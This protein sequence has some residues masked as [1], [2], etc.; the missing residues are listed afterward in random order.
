LATH[1]KTIAL[2]W[3]VLAHFLLPALPLVIAAGC[4]LYRLTTGRAASKVDATPFAPDSASASWFEN[5]SHR[6][7]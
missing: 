1:A 4:R 5:E 6:T 3:F 7:R 2:I